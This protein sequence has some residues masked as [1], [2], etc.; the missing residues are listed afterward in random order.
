MLGV[1]SE[2]G[3]LVKKNGSHSRRQNVMKIKGC[4]RRQSEIGKKIGLQSC[5]G[6]NYLSKG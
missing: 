3:R 4:I 1:G 2:G 6:E 5:V